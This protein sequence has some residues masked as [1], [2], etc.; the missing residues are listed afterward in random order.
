M[1]VV[2]NLEESHLQHLQQISIPVLRCCIPAHTE[3]F[4]LVVFV[5]HNG[6]RMHASQNLDAGT[7]CNM[8]TRTDHGTQGFLGSD[9]AV[10]GSWRIL[11]NITVAAVAG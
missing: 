8:L 2:G 9:G 3:G 4:H 6:R 10:E 11:A 7:Y 1:V 5:F